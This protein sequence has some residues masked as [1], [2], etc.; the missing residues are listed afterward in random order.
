MQH[1]LSRLSFTMAFFAVAAASSS[2]TSLSVRRVA[3]IGGGAGGLICAPKLRSSFAVVLFEES[4]KVG[5]CW[6][7]T[8]PREKRSPMYSNLRTNLPKQI[9]AFSE[10]H[11][12]HANLPSYLLHEDVQSYLE[13]FAMS[14]DLH[15]LIRYNC[16]VEMVEKMSE[17]RGWQIRSQKMCLSSQPSPQQLQP[18]QSDETEVEVFD[19]VVICNG[20]YSEPLIP[21]V[22]GSESFRG[23]QLHSIDYDNLPTSLQLYA[24]QRVLVV[25]SRSS[26]T[27]EKTRTQC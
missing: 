23:L 12:F 5:G 15:S 8:K 25:G 17:G 21:P 10:D 6:K 20:H 27:G 13:D 11:P 16:R 19:A 14:E 26:G 4:S 18:K 1:L 2:S 9:M 3:I 22:E 7:Y 24:N